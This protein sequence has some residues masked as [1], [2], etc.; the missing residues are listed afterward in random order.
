M[1]K[2]PFIECYRLTRRL[3]HFPFNDRCNPVMAISKGFKQARVACASG[4]PEVLF[5]CL[6][7]NRTL[8]FLTA[9]VNDKNE[10]RSV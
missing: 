7:G 4:R 3:E 9:A 10:Q 6:A 1:T 5:K 2:I 8:H